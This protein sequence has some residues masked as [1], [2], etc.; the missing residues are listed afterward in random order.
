MLAELIE[1]CEAL[2]GALSGVEPE[3]LSGVDC[4]Q[5]VETLARTEKR[6]AA[7][8][9]VAAARAAQCGAHKE[10]G[11]AD[12]TG[13]LDHV[14]GI[15]S[16]EARAALGVGNRL[17]A[18]PQT[19]DAVLSGEISLAQAAEITKTEA[20]VPGSEGDLLDLAARTG[21]AGLRDA[22]RKIRLDAQ[23][24]DQRHRRQRDARYLRYWR[25]DHGMIRIAGAF[26]PEVGV[27][28]TNRIDAE[29]DRIVRAARRDNLDAEQ[30]ERLTADALIKLVL[31][32]GTAPKSG[33]AELVLVCDIGAFQRGHTH[34]GETC[35]VIGAGPVPVSVARDLA[36]EAFIKAVLYDGVNIS[37]VAH[38]SRYKK[39]ELRTA[40]ALGPPPLFDGA[41]CTDE[42]CD[43]RYH[44]EWDHIDPVAHDGPTSFEN[45]APRCIPHH[46]QKTRRDREAGLLRPR[47]AGTPDHSGDPEPSSSDDA[48]SFP[49][50]A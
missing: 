38:Y 11:F 4:A 31:D 39:A 45:L 50:T 29:T 44:L 13:W 33:R 35:H 19:R 6:C 18:C 3:L 27:R 25:D 37:T 2:G 1:A 22:A 32:G 41:V 9:A 24:P 42:G 5:V 17:E 36:T 34:S 21:V 47:P 16:G 30:R 26:A 8:R 20:A 49:L 28:L 7:V 14:S 15:P 23:D 43:R 48:S 40:L 10:R 12:A 46:R